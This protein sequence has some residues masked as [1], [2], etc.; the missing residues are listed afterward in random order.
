LTA[1]V[2]ERRG[3][4]DKCSGSS[5]YQGRRG[6]CVEASA[7]HGLRDQRRIDELML[8]ETKKPESAPQI[9]ANSRRKR[10]PTGVA[11]SIT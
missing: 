3:Q 2:Q 4:S 1:A 7:P 6:K 9:I 11:L 8:I 10:T 5:Q